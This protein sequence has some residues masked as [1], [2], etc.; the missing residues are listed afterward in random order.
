MRRFKWHLV[1]FSFRALLKLP[2][3]IRAGKIEFIF[4]TIL[5]KGTFIRAD[6]SI[7]TYMGKGFVTVF[8]KAAHF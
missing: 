6:I 2:T 7:I 8:T 4:Y 5:T 3:T 1:G